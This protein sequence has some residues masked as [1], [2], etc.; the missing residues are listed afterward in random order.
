ML[1]LILLGTFRVERDGQAVGADE[2]RSRQTRTVLKMLADARDR[3]LPFERIVDAIWPEA[4]GD[5][6]RNNLQAAIRTLRRVLEPGLARG[7]ASAYIRTEGQAYRFVPRDCEID[8]DAFRSALRSATE[9]DHL[10]E[11]A[12]AIGAYAQATALYGGDYLA[13][14]PYADWTLAAREQLRGAY[15]DA[16]SRLASL[17]EREGRPDEMVVQLER[18]LAADRMRED[19]YRLLMRAHALAGRDAHALS[20]FDRCRRALRGELG[21]EPSVE[22]R[23]ERERIAERD[24]PRD[25]EVV[26]MV[27]GFVPP[28]VGRERELALLRQ[29]WTRASAGRGALVLVNG[30]A[31]IGKTRLLLHF[32]DQLAPQTD[33]LA[34]SAYEADTLSYAV[35]SRLVESRLER[36]DGLRHIDPAGPLAGVLASIVPALH[37]ASREGPTPA[38][39]STDPAQALEVLTRA[40]L[41]RATAGPALIVIDDAQWLDERSARWLGYALHHADRVLVVATMRAGEGSPA[42]LDSVCADLA[43]EERLVRIEIGPLS[44]GE[45]ARLVA[46]SGEGRREIGERLHSTTSGN[47]FFVVE[48]LRSGVADDGTGALP[49]SVRDAVAAR[50]RRCGAQERAALA[51]LAVLGDPARAEIVAATAGRTLPETLD[52]LDALLARR[53]V[54]ARDDGRYEI[55]HPLIQRAVHDEVAAGRRHELHR[56]AAAA[57]AGPEGGGPARPLLRHLV[58]SDAGAAE[59]CRAAERAGDEAMAASSYREAADAYALAADA[60]RAL[61]SGGSRVTRLRL[62]ERRADALH[63]SGRSAEA[64]SI[65]EEL[66]EA[67]REP[68]SRA[69]L[70]RKC[71]QFYGDT[72]LAEALLLLQR[73]ELELAQDTGGAARGE[74]ARIEAARAVPHFYG[75]DFRA[76]VADC[77]RAIVLLDGLP[78]AG[79]VWDEI[80]IRAGAAYQRL[81]DLA[82]AGAAYR[83]ARARARAN[84]DDVTAARADVSLALLAQHHG[85]LGEALALCESGLRVFERAALPRFLVVGIFDQGYV[86]VDMGDLAGARAAYLDALR[87]AEAIAS[88]YWI[89]HVTVGLGGVEVRLGARGAK[90]TLERAIELADGLGNRQ[91]KAHACVFLA[92]L[93]LLQGDA[94]EARELVLRALALGEEIGDAHTLREG[95]A[96]LASAQIPLGDATGAVETSTRGADAARAGGF[97]LAEARNRVALGQALRAQGTAAEGARQLAQAE[98]T[99][100]AAGARYDL[101]QALLARAARTAQPGRLLEEARALAHDAGARPLAARIALASASSAGV[102]PTA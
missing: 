24:R 31:G 2:W 71:A 60:A 37:A 67:T 93:A 26:A 96:V 58:A 76:A 97:V 18:G 88:A 13:D 50:V 43:R 73:A 21:L 7:T 12:A 47:P 38:S 28:F 9:H 91:R 10:S 89:M 59:I 4:E 75:S 34:A 48:M 40:V 46:A 90:R 77:E 41:P 20:V 94:R 99:F 22:T 5:T 66:L 14:E 1:R 45:V 69:R 49:S 25:A 56:R 85:R 62:L 84:A 53:L 95:C 72:K 35:A 81:G 8:V 19:L 33:V 64:V 36:P 63:A 6:G 11:T 100:R 30:E 101:A 15:L 52:T 39:G 80:D 29:A 42:A 102:Q 82:R 79:D 78:D 83:R 68:L 23:R 87:R 92:E 3:P 27:H 16:V 55:E 17:L 54:R 74:L 86:L 70:L 65:C 98:R 32:R 57:L 44:R 61:D 51:V